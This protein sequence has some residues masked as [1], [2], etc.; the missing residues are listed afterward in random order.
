M[1]QD[2][3]GIER[4]F[5]E[6]AIKSVSG[7]TRDASDGRI[8]N[9]LRNREHVI[10]T[11]IELIN[12]G[13]DGTLDEVIDRSGVARRSIYRYFDDLSDL[14]MQVFRRVAAAAAAD[15]TLPNPGVGPLP[16]R[17]A[18]YAALRL[19]TLAATHAFGMMARRRLA[20]VDDVQNGLTV[21]TSIVRAQLTIQFEPELTEMDDERRE[22]VLDTITM[23]TSFESYDVLLRQLGRP[24]DV[25]ETTWNE[26]LTMLL[27]VG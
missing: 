21:I 9:R 27:G 11:F 17:I 16:Q 22:R 5:E 3:T 19:E 6:R 10:D 4:L 23:L 18:A 15:A 12:E 26:A 14:S 13:K 2:H 24:V 25:V 1:T 7:T 8:A 20:A